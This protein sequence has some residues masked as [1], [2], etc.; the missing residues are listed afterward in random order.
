MPITQWGRWEVECFWL[1]D[2]ASLERFTHLTLDTTHLGTRGLDVVAVYERLAERVAHVH[3]SDYNA[4]TPVRQHI[5][6]GDG[7]LRLP[8]LL[9]MLIADAY[10]GV[11]TLE[12]DPEALEVGNEGAVRQNL[13]RS[14]EFCWRQGVGIKRFA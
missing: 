12:T 8:E 1:G 7:S 2:I 3:V 4:G 9:R 14:C 11:V 13:R 5:L 10:D 6:P